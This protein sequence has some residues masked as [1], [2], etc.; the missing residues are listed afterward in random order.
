M[1]ALQLL[2]GLYL[3]DSG[4]TYTVLYPLQR[5][6]QTLLHL[7]HLHPHYPLHLPHFPQNHLAEDLSVLVQDF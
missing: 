5:N 7:P 6:L 1:N 2:Q 4:L 3:P